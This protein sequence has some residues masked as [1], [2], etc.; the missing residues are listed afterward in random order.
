[1]GAKVRICPV[2]DV[3]VHIDDS[4]MDEAFNEGSAR[5]KVYNEIIGMCGQAHRLHTTE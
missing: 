1:M 3:M 4:T 2:A 5:F